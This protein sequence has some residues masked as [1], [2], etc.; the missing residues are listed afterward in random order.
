VLLS[1][2]NGEQFDT[3]YAGLFGCVKT[4]TGEKDVRLLLARGGKI[5]M[6]R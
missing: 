1:V 4:R 2:T 5:G 3:A 6:R